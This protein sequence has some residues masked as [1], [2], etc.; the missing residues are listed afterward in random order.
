MKCV[1]A[2]L[3]L[4]G[5]GGLAVPSKASQVSLVGA[6][7]TPNRIK[8]LPLNVVPTNYE[9]ELELRPQESGYRGRVSIR[10]KLSESVDTFWLH[11]S[12]QQVMEAYITPKDGDKMVA[13][14][15][16]T[17]ASTV[18]ISAS[19]RLAPGLY[20][21]DL[22]FSGEMKTPLMGMY[23]VEHA[24]DWYIYTQIEPLGARLAFPCFDEPRF[25]TP[26]KISIITRRCQSS[27]THP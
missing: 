26:F 27:Q 8:R 6:S 20:T 5:C 21:V 25:K 7:E 14:T 24:G 13:G 3:V 1:L 19:S 4:L 22:V 18:A 17:G 12:N 11:S 15:I 2:S 10:V 9:L 16:R 23:R